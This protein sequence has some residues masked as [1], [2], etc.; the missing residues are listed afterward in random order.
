MAKRLIKI[1]NMGIAK[2]AAIRAANISHG[3]N[4]NNFFTYVI[5]YQY[6]QIDKIKLIISSQPYP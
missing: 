1:S 6:Y 4:L 3:F 5:R 2:I